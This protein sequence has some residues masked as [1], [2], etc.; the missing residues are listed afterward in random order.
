MD[1][2][3]NF[4]TALFYFFNGDIANSLF[5]KIMPFVTENRHWII[6]Y[7]VLFTWLFWKGGKNGRVAGLLLI[8]GLIIADQLSS[9]VV[10]E[11]VGRLR[12]C[13]ALP[14][15]RL[16]V[17]CGGGLSFPSS[18]AANTF[19]GAVVLSNYYRHYAWIYFSIAAIVS[20]SRVYCGVHYP[21]DILGGA[22]L[23][24]TI[25][26]GIIYIANKI[27]ILKIEGNRKNYEIQ[28]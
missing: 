8:A 17:S 6:V 14:D 5:D 7:I 20:F 13:K 28:V 12:P 3:A 19:F 27:P 9:S 11:L 25:G 24:S 22:V 16:L 1:F 21:L 10:K 23:G 4:D 26:I 2:L 18:H 15:V